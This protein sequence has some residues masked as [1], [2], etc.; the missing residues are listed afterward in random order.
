MA[1]ETAKA[2]KKKEKRP[3]AQKRV[4]QSEKNRLRNRAFKA[5]VRTAI[6]SFDDTLS[7]GDANASEESLRNVYSILDKAAQKGIFKLNKAS[8]TKARLTARLSAQ[9]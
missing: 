3:T 2:E 6:R 7:A 8:R 5:T 4:L 1:K 9:A